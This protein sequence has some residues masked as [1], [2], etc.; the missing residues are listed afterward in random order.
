MK[1]EIINQLVKQNEIV[2][3]LIVDAKAEFLENLKQLFADNPT[4]EQIKIRINN[5]E[6]ADGDVTSFSLYYEDVKVTDTDNN[7]FERN[8]YGSSDPD[9]NRSHPLVMAVFDLFNTYDVADL[10]EFI[11]GDEYDRYLEINR[12]NVSD[13][14]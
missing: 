4:L 10:Y 6:F 7:I 9:R 2:S 5:H 1:T 11:F 12:N 8:D 3:K 14:K 13:Y